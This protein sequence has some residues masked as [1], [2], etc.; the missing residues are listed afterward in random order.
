MITEQLYRREE[1]VHK[2]RG[3]QGL[4]F[5]VGKPAIFGRPKCDDGADRDSS[6]ATDH[7]RRHSGIIIPWTK[8]GPFPSPRSMNSTM[9]SWFTS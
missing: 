2:S 7:E 5:F 6:T 4:H 1:I 8:D 9:S 3:M